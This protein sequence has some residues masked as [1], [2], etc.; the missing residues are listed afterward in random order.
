MKNQTLDTIS[1]RRSCRSYSD[2]PV[3]A[4]ELKT[5]LDAG[6]LAPSA[7]NLQERRI[8]VV[9][10]KAL[11][12]ELNE[13]VMPTLGDRPEGYHVFHRAPVVIVLS[14]AKQAR[15]G[16]EDIGIMI[17]N[18]CLAAES[19]GLGTCI[20]GLPQRLL[21]KEEA[22]HWLDRLAVPADYDSVLCLS[23]G[24]KADADIPAKP[25]NYDV[26]TYVD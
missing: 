23:L 13:A 8:T 7:R 3:T 18:M 12:D 22:R 1:A 2:L 9:R 20:L 4:E 16:K 19:I 26:I 5:V 14:A 21:E 10:N 15:W 25:R 11:I 24:H 6:I 17:Q